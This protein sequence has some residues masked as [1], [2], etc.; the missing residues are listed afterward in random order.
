MNPKNERTITSRVGN[1]LLIGTVH[2]EV[3]HDTLNKKTTKG[4]ILKFGF[5][6]FMK[7][8]RKDAKFSRK[9]RGLISGRLTEDHRVRGQGVMSKH[10]QN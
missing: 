1:D 6:L 3:I 4:S 10:R 5:K 9:R 7:L 8:L 2:K